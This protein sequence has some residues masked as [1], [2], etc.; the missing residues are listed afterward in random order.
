MLLVAVQREST[1]QSSCKHWCF[2]LCYLD[3]PLLFPVQSGDVENYHLMVI[4][5]MVKYSL[6]LS[7][8]D[9]PSVFIVYQKY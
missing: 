1:N 6:P 4:M 2:L 5:M 8:L 3:E 7:L 9:C